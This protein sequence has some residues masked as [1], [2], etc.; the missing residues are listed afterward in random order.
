MGDGQEPARKEKRVGYDPRLLWDVDTDRLQEGRTWW[1]WWWI[2]FIKDPE[3]PTRTRQAMILHSTKNSD[4]VRVRDHTWRRKY[5]LRRKTRDPPGGGGT[6]RVLEFHGM[7]AAWFFD[8]RK[9]YDPLLL[10]DLEYDVV[11][12]PDGS[13]ALHARGRQDLDMSGDGE[14]YTVGIAD[15]PGHTQMEFRM[16]PWNPW[17]SEHRFARSQFTKKWSYDILKIHA[18]KMEGTLKKAGA[19][20]EP[21]EGTAYFQKV[22]VNAPQ[23]PWYWVVLH[24]EN[25]MYIDYFQPNIGAQMWRR[26]TRQRSVFDRWWW[27]EYKLSSSLDIYDPE[28]GVQHRIKKFRLR[29]HYPPGSDMPVFVVDGQGPTAKAH[30][31]LST[32]SRAYWSFAQ[33]HLGGLLTSRLFYNEYPAELTAFAFED[34]RTGRKVGREQLGFVAAN[35]E[36]TW[37]KLY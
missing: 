7:S 28:T 33:K 3:H 32:Y 26:T 24:A 16:G 8:G 5:R 37:G 6:E 19:R 35:C 23:V 27:G 4:T 30:M 22:R 29:H 21:I 31:E 14:H 34:L 15:G 13:G 36:Q 12:R 11:E 2:F 20:D 25:G 18:M 17:L 10:E 1:W 9:M